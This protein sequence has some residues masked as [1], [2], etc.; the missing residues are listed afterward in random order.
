[1]QTNPKK[2]KPAATFNELA[3]YMP[4]TSFTDKWLGATGIVVPYGDLRSAACL[5][6]GCD[7]CGLRCVVRQEGLRPSW[8]DHCLYFSTQLDLQLG[9]VFTFTFH[10]LN[11]KY[12]NNSQSEG[13]A[14]L[15]V[16]TVLAPRALMT[17]THCDRGQRAARQGPT[18][19]NFTGSTAYQNRLLGSLTGTAEARYE[20]GRPFWK[21]LPQ[22]LK[23]CPTSLEC[24]LRFNRVSTDFPTWG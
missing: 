17:R 18:I 4:S 15:A 14:P 1:M 5:V 22:Q 16:F 23:S 24:H 21:T 3:D 19:C 6:S 13:F 7:G 10:V 8:S 20:R 12:E 2:D 11:F 9:S